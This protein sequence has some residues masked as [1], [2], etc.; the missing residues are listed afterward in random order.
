M[1]PPPLAGGRAWEQPGRSPRGLSG[2]HERLRPGSLLQ[3]RPWLVRPLA[4]P[5]PCQLSLPRA[6]SSRG[7]REKPKALL[8]CQGAP[9]TGCPRLARKHAVLLSWGLPCDRP[10]AEAGPLG[11]VPERREVGPGRWPTLRSQA[12]PSSNP[13]LCTEP[14]CQL[15]SVLSPPPQLQVCTPRTRETAPARWRWRGRRGACLTRTRPA[16]W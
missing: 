3:S 11:P 7:S 2:T 5:R 10:L 6:G 1:A 13:G 9:D 8:S 15:G 12:G 14:R 4:C 16:A